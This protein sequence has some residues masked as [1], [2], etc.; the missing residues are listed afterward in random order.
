MRRAAA[1]AAASRA[2]RALLVEN[3]VAGP[4]GAAP[5]RCRGFSNL[6]EATVY[7]GPSPGSAKRVTLRTVASKYERGDIITMVT[8][9]DFPS[10]VHVR[11]RRRAAAL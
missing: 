5:L 9:Y 8:A 3:S 1:L 6:P 4:C 11:P 10:A 7:G 2:A